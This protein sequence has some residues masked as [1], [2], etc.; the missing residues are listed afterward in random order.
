M[1]TDKLHLIRQQHGYT[2]DGVA[3]DTGITVS[4]WEAM[5]TGASPVDILGR[6][7]AL[8]WLRRLAEISGEHSAVLMDQAG[9]SDDARLERGRPALG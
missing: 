2:L 6:G 8:A 9:L 1:F 3:N 7:A 5:E 4:Q